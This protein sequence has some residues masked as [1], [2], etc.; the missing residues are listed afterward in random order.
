MSDTIEVA[1]RFNG[2]LDSGNGGYS[3]GLL[4]QQLS[5]PVEV[6]LRSPVPL[7]KRMRVSRDGDVARLLHDDHLIAEA[8][9]VRHVE[10]EMPA[11]VGVEA[12]REASTRY[13]GLRG[14]MFSR[15]FVCGL[16][17]QD[18][19]EVFAGE[20]EG[21]EVVASAWTTPEWAAG[22]S[23]DVRPEFVWAVLDCPTYFAAH[24]GQ[25]LTMSVLAQMTAH[26]QKPVAAGQEHVVMSWP[27]GIDGRKR[28][29]GAAVLSAD[30]E[31]LAVA[32][33]LLI[34]LR[35]R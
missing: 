19:F 16:D 2:P 12:A 11:P 21:R 5:G 9:E 28:H 10:A 17:R 35:E 20:V 26:V 4:A 32:R 6:S 24:H 8:R 14:E 3:A 23:G 27:I 29:A 13:R 34:E 30:G 25:D 1:S 7:D 18:S 22:D 33:A 15:C 31:P